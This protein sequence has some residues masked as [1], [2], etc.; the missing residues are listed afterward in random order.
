MKASMHSLLA[1][2]Y[3]HSEHSSFM[4]DNRELKN[5]G[6][7][8]EEKEGRREGQKEG[9]KERIRKEGRKIEN[10]HLT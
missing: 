3:Q 7:N 4:N 10:C 2:I 8:N 9:R 1:I 6:E 5:R